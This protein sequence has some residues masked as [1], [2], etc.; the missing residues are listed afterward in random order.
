MKWSFKNLRKSYENK[1]SNG[2]MYRISK[3]SLQSRL[4]ILFILLSTISAFDELMKEVDTVS[5][6]LEKMQSALR[7][8]NLELPQLRQTAVSY[9]SGIGITGSTCEHRTMLAT[10]GSQII[11]M[12][13]THE[14][15]MKLEALSDS[16]AALSK[17]FVVK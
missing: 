14:V 6:N 11:E 4:L 1:E 13:T 3:I 16:L 9:A 5:G 10:S 15:G 17:R 8:L 2:N 7:E 12:E